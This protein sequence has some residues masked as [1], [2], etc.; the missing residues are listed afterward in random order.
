MKQLIELCL[1]VH[2]IEKLNF[3]DLLHYR[4]GFH[5]RTKVSQILREILISLK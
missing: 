4:N 3:M 2:F 5:V 1:S